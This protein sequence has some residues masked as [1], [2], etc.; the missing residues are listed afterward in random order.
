MTVAFPRLSLETQSIH[1]SNMASNSVCHER[2]TPPKTAENSSLSNV[3]VSK[4]H[5]T[6]TTTTVN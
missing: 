1:P 4:L 3:V 6:T 2:N 5:S